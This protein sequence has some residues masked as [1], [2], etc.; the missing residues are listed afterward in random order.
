LVE[1]EAYAIIHIDRKE[2]RI[3]MTQRSPENPFRTGSIG[4]S[5]QDN[6]VI[7]GKSHLC[8]IN[9]VQLGTKGKHTPKLGTSSKG[10]KK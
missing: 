1:T 5:G 6:I 3:N 10:G 2:W 7:D 8:N 9:I 4:Y